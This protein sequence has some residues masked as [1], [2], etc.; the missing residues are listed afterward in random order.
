M[1]EQSGFLFE[2]LASTLRVSTPL[3]FAALAG[4]VSERSGVINIALEGMLL[5]G[6]FAGAAVTTATGTPWAGAVAAVIA[7]LAFAGIYGASVIRLRA[8]QIVAGT[9]MNMLAAG[10]TPF[11][12]KLLYGTTTG[13]PSIALSGRFSSEP[14]WMA[15]VLGLLV[16]GWLK[17]TPSGAWVRFAGEKPEALAAAG[18]RVQR[19]RWV[20]VLTSGAIAG[21]GGA[22]LSIFLASSFSRNMT[23]G[24]GFMALAALIFGKWRPIPAVAAC[25]LFGLAEAGQIRLQGVILWGTEP[26]PVQF[27]QILPYLVTIGILAG[28]VGQA[29]APQAL[30]KSYER[31]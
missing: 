7:G 8:D 29:R 10:I 4:L 25:L 2:L 17:Y 19:V 5:V 11:M 12:C 27:I 22:S 6:A 20:A 13:T 30:G 18:V 16:W 3:I 31:A 15:A 1:T 26:V 23:A 21:L 9:A 28:F 14:L 24:R